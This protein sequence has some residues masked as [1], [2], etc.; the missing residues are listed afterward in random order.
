M[1]V[2]VALLLPLADP[3]DEH[4]AIN[5]ADAAIASGTDRDLSLRMLM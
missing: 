1:V 2:N 5:E 3:D 4:A